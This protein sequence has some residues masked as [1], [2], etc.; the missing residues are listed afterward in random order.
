MVENNYNYQS[1]NNFG[2]DNYFLT[3]DRMR[4]TYFLFYIYLSL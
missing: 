3:E 2:K 4:L 1:D